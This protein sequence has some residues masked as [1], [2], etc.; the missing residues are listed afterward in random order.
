MRRRGS[1]RSEGLSRAIVARF[2]DGAWHN[3]DEVVAAC[4]HL[5]PLEIA[6]RRRVGSRYKAGVPLDEQVEQGR[7]AVIRSALHEMG[8]EPG[9]TGR[10]KWAQ[11]RLPARAY[12]VPV[13]ERHYSAKLTAEQVR[14]IRVRYARG[15][16]T[17]AVL[18]QEYGVAGTSVSQIVRRMKWKHVE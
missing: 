16:V 8:A 9:G 5:I 12:G 15:G 7:R 11:F 18:G 13:G 4:G 10:L 17:M 3:V 1:L 6:L 2:A 14:E